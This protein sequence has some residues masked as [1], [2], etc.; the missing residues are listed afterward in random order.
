[1]NG[2]PHDCPR[3]HLDPGAIVQKR[4]IQGDERMPFEL[5]AHTERRRDSGDAREVV[6]CC[7]RSRLTLLRADLGIA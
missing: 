7:L 6:T 4:G 2:L 5:L 3:R 1:M